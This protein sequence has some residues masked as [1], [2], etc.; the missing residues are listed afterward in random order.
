[1][2]FLNRLGWGGYASAKNGLV[3]TG[4]GGVICTVTV[5]VG[6][7]QLAHFLVQ[8]HFGKDLLRGLLRR[9]HLGG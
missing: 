5:N 8:V 9:L 3:V 4:V 1:M 2:V 6:P 7:Q